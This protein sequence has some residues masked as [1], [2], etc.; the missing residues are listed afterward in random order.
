MYNSHD[1]IEYMVMMI[2]MFAKKYNM[3]TQEA[4]C[5]LSRY[6]ALNLI[7]EH[8]GI[9]HT[10]TFEDMIDGITAFCKRNGG[11]PL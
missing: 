10:Q 9:M 1:I 11:C 2:G 8:Y 7:Q 5:Y 6:G 4:Q 3:S